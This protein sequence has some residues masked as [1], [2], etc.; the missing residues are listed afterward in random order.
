MK[1]LIADDSPTTRFSLRNNLIE[2]GYEVE[3]ACDGREAWRLLNLDDPPRIAILDWMMP[4]MEGVEIC[5]KLQDRSNGPFVYTILLT[6]RN[7]S[8]D[9]VCGLESGAHNFQ[10]KPYSPIEL[11]SHVNVGKR[12]VES[13]DKLKEYAAQM[14]RLATTDSLTGILNRRHFLK[15]GEEE[16]E[17]ACRY[18]RSLSILLMDI[19]HFK[20]V[21]DTYGHAAGDEALRTM[22]KMCRLAL[23]TND[24]FG[25]MG[26]EEFAAVL[27]EIDIKNALEVSERIRMSLEKL[28]IDYDGKPIRITVSI[29]V[30]SLES[31][32]RN[33]E[34]LLK[35]ADKALYTAKNNG[36]N[37]IESR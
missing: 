35:R 37:R 29:G 27:P 24:I 16:I 10:F 22:T 34:S 13:D 33:I 4:E 23:R 15:C 20:N 11:R 25:R 7:D 3:E 5:R 21:N 12:L 9:L 30:T 28:E 2:W 14:E 26:G 18:E 19:D 17:R 1:V 32:D 36:R 31:L 6:S 8:K